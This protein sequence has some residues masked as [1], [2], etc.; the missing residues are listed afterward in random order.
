MEQIVL[1]IAL[2]VAAYATALAIAI[3]WEA[4]RQAK[5]NKAYLDDVKRGQGEKL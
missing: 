4:R 2:V 3:L 1:A 5:T